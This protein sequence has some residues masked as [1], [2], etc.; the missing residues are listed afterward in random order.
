MSLQLF[1]IRVLEVLFFTG[2]LGSVVV[3]LISF[4]EDGKEL[5]GGK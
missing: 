4:V 1:G 3:V 5:L 2:L